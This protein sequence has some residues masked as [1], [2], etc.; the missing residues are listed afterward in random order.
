[1]ADPID[2]DAAQP[3]LSLPSRQLPSAMQLNQRLSTVAQSFNL[4][5]PDNGDI[6]EFMAVGVDST[7][8]DVLHRVVH[9]TGRERPGL[10]TIR[11]PKGHAHKR[12]RQRRRKNDPNRMD[13]DQDHG[14][15]SPSDQGGASDDADDNDDDDDERAQQGLPTP[16]LKTFRNLFTISPGVYSLISPAVYK[17]QTGIS[18]IE[19][20]LNNPTKPSVKEVS[21][22]NILPH[23]SPVKPES[24]MNGTGNDTS[25]S[26]STIPLPIIQRLP[27]TSNGFSHNKTE[28]VTQNLINTGLLKLDKA[29]R[30]GEGGEEVAGGGGAVAGGKKSKHNLHWKYEDPAI[31]LK[32]V[33][34]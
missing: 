1:M 22:D 3:P 17:L 12:R 9:L 4:S 21:I 24:H 18:E 29:G 11:V 8:G 7:L 34:G 30:P 32:D 2:L 23:A 20:E 14:R 33:L 5:L 6:G 10:G 25:P 15:S 28:S 26:K 16:N 27:Y 13:V 19:A 31:I